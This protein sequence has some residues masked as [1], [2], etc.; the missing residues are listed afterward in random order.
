M[1]GVRRLG[2]ISY[3]PLSGEGRIDRRLARDGGRLDGPPPVGWSIV[4]GDYFETMG[5][6]LLH[7]R[8]FADTDGAARR[9]S[10][11]VD[12][13]LA[14]RW[15]PS[16]AAAVGQPIRIGSGKTRRVRTIV[17]V[18][19]HVSHTG[20]GRSTAPDGSTRRRRRSTSAGCT[21]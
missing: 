17:G 6:A 2:A 20:P 1:P 18:V 13:A 7:G 19:R 10:P 11:I 14:R 15:W 16:A 12:D 8:L 21:R 9:P 4:R 3:L 5:I